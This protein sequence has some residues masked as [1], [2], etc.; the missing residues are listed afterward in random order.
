MTK[1]LTL[2]LLI[3]LAWGQGEDNFSIAGYAITYDGNNENII[4]QFSPDGDEY[5][6]QTQTDGGGF[7]ILNESQANVRK[8]IT[9]KPK[10]MFYKEGYSEKIIGLKITV[11]DLSLIHI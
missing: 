7:F 6:S 5:S 8:A 4:V 2:L 1:Y 11:D 3:G 10:V 9:E